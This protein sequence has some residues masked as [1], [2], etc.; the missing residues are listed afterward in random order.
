MAFEQVTIE[1]DLTKK[2]LRD[3]YVAAV[4]RL[5]EI[6]D[7]ATGM[8]LDAARQALRELAVI[9]LRLLRA[10]KDILS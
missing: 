4:A 9:E 6:R 7:T 1:T 5:E 10:L 3:N 8:D 2:D